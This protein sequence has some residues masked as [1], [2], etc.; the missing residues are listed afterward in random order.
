MR[1]IDTVNSAQISAGLY[2]PASEFT[3]KTLL[4]DGNL[5]FAAIWFSIGGNR[6][7]CH[8]Q[9]LYIKRNV[10]FHLK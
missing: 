10:H 9:P 5:Q 1:G 7:I 4:T 3:T 8:V 2:E 6:V